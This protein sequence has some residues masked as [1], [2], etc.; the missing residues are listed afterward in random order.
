MHLLGAGIDSTVEVVTHSDMGATVISIG[1]GST[2]DVYAKKVQVYTSPGSETEVRR[3]ADDYVIVKPNV[4]GYGLNFASF[5]PV[6]NQIP[7][8]DS[9]ISAAD[10]GNLTLTLKNVS[11]KNSS[12][13]IRKFTAG[14]VSIA[15]SF[16]FFISSTSASSSDGALPFNPFALIIQWDMS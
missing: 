2:V 13:I 16:F 15:S 8:P 5:P 1:R 10:T 14:P 9:T 11:T 7:T 4:D 6:D 3:N 12:T